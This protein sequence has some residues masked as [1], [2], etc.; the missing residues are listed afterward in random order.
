VA[1]WR[2]PL[3][4]RFPSFHVQP[5]LF[6]L[7]GDCLINPDGRN[8]WKLIVSLPCLATT[9]YHALSLSNTDSRLKAPLVTVI[10][11]LA[12]YRPLVLL[13]AKSLEAQGEIFFFQLNPCSP[14]PYVTSSLTRRQVCLLWMCLAFRQVYI[15]HIY[16]MLLKILP[17][18]L[19]K[20]PLSAQYLRSRFVAWEF[21]AATEF[22]FPRLEV[23]Q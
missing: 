1:W 10:L 2:L 21:V 17:C 20:S 7:A 9:G 19:Y 22:F 14:S 4:C 23:N 16:S 18:A 3:Q 12:V 15:S 13:G 11:R 8:S 6:S 5:L